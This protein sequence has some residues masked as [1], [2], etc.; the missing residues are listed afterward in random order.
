MLNSLINFAPND[1][2]IRI[3]PDVDEQGDWTGDIQIGMLTTDDN[4]M[5]DQD[6]AHIKVLTDMLIA[7]IPLIE[8]DADIRRK[9]FNL[10]DELEF[11]DSTEQEPLVASR[12]GNVV[13][14]NF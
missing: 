12:D 10:V 13:K 6:F 4:T 3:S 9:L 8:D 11:E 7:A 2:I 14:V 1:F 5:K